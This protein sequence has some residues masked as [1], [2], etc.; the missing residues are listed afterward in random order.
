[1]RSSDLNDKKGLVIPFMQDGSY[2]FKKG[3]EMYDE[4]HS[5]KAMEYIRR[6]MKIEPEE[7]VFICQLAIIL[8]E[9]GEYRRSNELL[10]NVI[11]DLDPKM[12]Q[13]YFFMA[14]NLAH[15]GEFDEAKAYLTIYLSMDDDGEFVEDANSLLDII[16]KEL[17]GGL[18]NNLFD[19]DENGSED[20]VMDLLNLGEFEEAEKKVHIALTENPEDWNLYAY[21][22]ESYIHQD[23]LSEAEPILRDLLMKE[24]PNFFAQ[25]EM[26]VLLYKKQDPHASVWIDNLKNIRPMKDWDCYFLA[27]TLYYVGEYQ[28]SYHLYEKFLYTSNFLKRSAY[29]HQMAVVAWHCKLF[30][31]AQK[32]WMRIESTEHREEMQHI[33]SY[34]LKLIRNK[35]DLSRNGKEFLYR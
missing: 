2:F 22:A 11:D 1:M 13:C 27:R 18:S 35:A 12:S 4:G 15:L 3:L 7:P 29:L 33:A 25:C 6:A 20:I 24:E 16:D 19:I 5:E 9:H 8:S 31:K 14:N 23:R 21:L 28:A 17:D 32:L 34:Y 30:E 10:I 26:A